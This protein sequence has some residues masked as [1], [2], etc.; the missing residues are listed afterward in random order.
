MDRSEKW[1]Q[2]V[3]AAR[4][5]TSKLEI[6][7][8]M[9]LNKAKK[10][11]YFDE[12]GVLRVCSME[13]GLGKIEGIGKL[14]NGDLYVSLCVRRF[15]GSQNEVL[16]GK[17]VT[18][19]APGITK[20][21][22]LKICEGVRIV[23]RTKAKDPSRIINSAS[24]GNMRE[25]GDILDMHVYPR[26]GMPLYESDLVVILGE[27]GGIGCPVEGHLWWNKRNWGYIQF[28]DADRVTNEYIDYARDIKKYIP[29]G[30]SAAI[31][32]QATDVEGEVNGLVTYDR[33]V[34]KMDAERVKAINKEI[35][36][37]LK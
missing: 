28:D 11:K 8:Y 16:F 30:M 31:Y 2:K 5:D 21:E 29:Q 6:P 20:E 15:L 18:A 12:S 19:A 17:A 33:K 37:S 22:F 13:E 7:A 27:Y 35:I 36:N 34:V 1:N 3:T 26:P 14:L 10:V 4:L 9:A 25:C 32:T 23:P 24:G